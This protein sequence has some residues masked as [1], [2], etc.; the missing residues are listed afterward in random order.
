M[1]NNET[2]KMTYSAKQQA[3]IQAIR[4]KY[5]PQEEDKMAK[6]RALDAGATNKAT[7]VS[8]LVG[9]LGALVLGLG[10]SLVMT[11]F[12]AWLGTAALACGI[13][14]GV[15]GLCVLAL[16]YPLYVRMLKRERERIAPEILR[17]S[18]ELLSQD[19]R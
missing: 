7:A 14:V 12:G 6:L 9:V 13:A 18:E 5:A 4:K 17:L 19:H 3:E 16:A 11:D 1:E 10:M 2:F 8:V 15:V